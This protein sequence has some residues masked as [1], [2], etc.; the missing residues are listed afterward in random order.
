V[1]HRIETGSPAEVARALFA[2]GSWL[3]FAAVFI[4]RAALGWRGGARPT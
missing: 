4:V 2:Y 1:G 3:L